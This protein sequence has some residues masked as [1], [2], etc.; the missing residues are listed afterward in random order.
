MQEIPTH[1]FANIHF[2]QRTNLIKKLRYVSFIIN[3]IILIASVLVFLVWIFNLQG[4]NVFLFRNLTIFPFSSVLF[5]FSGIVLLFGAKRHLMRTHEETEK[6]E[7]PWWNTWIPI[8]LAA[9]TAALGLINLVQFNNI[10]VLSLFRVSPAEGLC[11]FLVGLGLIPPFTRIL[12]RFHITQF[13][14]FIVS[15][16]NIFIILEYLFQLFSSSPMQHIVDI[17]PATT[18]AFAVFCFGI[19]LR[20]SNRGFL[21]NFTLDS[22]ASTFAL[23]LFLINLLAIPLIALF[24]LTIMQKTSYNMYQV[25]SVVVVCF[26]VISCSI[27]W[28][29]VKL[30]YTYEL[31]HLLMRESLRI[32]NIDLTAEQEELRKR[33]V[34]L[35][36]E[37]QQ[38]LDKLSTQ[39]SLRDLVDKLG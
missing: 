32:H 20:W 29:N 30:L 22:T 1:S 39:D 18:L 28:I 7:Y 25:L 33:M 5:L 23:R 36:E 34:Q 37:K 14:I 26:T 12:H 27:L 38:Y 8:F 2:P 13:I 31:E 19:L 4:I 10:G 21:G 17:P 3:D 15:G 16:L 35:V 11:F 9:I 6:E 24:V